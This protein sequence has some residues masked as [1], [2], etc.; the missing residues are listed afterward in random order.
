MRPFLKRYWTYLLAVVAGIFLAVSYFMQDKLWLGV[1]WTAFALIQLTNLY[2]D[3][4]RR[5][6]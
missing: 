3:Y 1:I 4:Q 6:K 5:R 2:F